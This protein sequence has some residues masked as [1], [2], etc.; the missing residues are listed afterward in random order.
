MESKSN[1]ATVSIGVIIDPYPWQNPRNSLDVNDDGFVTA[2]DALIVINDLNFNG[3]RTL[4]NPP[5]PPNAPPP[6]YDTS[7]DNEI[8]AI[9]A[10]LVINHINDEI[11]GGE[12]EGEV[13]SAFV[14]EDPLVVLPMLLMPGEGEVSV[15]TTDNEV[16]HRHDRKR[17]ELSEEHDYR[18]RIGR[19]RQEQCAALKE[20]LQEHG[21]DEL[22]DEIAEDVSRWQDD[23]VWED[24]G[25]EDW[26]QLRR[27]WFG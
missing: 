24:V 10:L 12:G 2:I 15:D 23:E 5:L 17:G 9:D 6:Y 21:F 14:A 19:M 13:S 18:L 8:A 26:K 7:G 16:T 4:P 27:R 20:H 22:L 3:A 25:R 11:G 1:V